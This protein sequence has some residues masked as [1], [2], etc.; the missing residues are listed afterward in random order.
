MMQKEKPKPVVN[1]L[2]AKL[3][4]MIKE[5]SLQERVEGKFEEKLSKNCLF[6]WR[7]NYEIE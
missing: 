1:S 5:K 7:L 4:K 6:G 3:F 2:D